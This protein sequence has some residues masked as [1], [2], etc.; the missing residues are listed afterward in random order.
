MKLEM[1]HFRLA[2]SDGI[3]AELLLYSP[4]PGIILKAQIYLWSKSAEL[5]IY[6]LTKILQSIFTDISIRLY[7][8]SRHSLAQELS[9]SE[10]RS[11]H[12]TVPDFPLNYLKTGY[13]YHS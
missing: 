10:I 1:E 12:Y 3:S 5:Y 13:S 8:S 7:P 4:P 2:F 11:L 6:S 9:E